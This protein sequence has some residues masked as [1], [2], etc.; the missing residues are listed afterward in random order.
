MVKATG[1]TSSLFNVV[2]SGDMLLPT[3]AVPVLASWFQT[4]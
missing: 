3:A 1:L 2:S 4:G